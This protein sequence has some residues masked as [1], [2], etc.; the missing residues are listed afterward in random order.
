[1]KHLLLILALLLIPASAG[2]M[3]KDKEAFWFCAQMG[4]VES[5]KVM[6]TTY[7]HKN[8]HD[9][10]HDKKA[11]QFEDIVKKRIGEVWEP[12]YPAYCVDHSE[13]KKAQKHLDEV[14]K[15]A[16]K[17]NFL[18]YFIDLLKERNKK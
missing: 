16:K 9:W 4:T 13:L 11:E 12:Q 10:D 6:A 1:M 5:A 7:V 17:K 2:S 3:L 15:R 14:V 18:I 8:M